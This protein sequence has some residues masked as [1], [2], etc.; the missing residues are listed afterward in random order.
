MKHNGKILVTSVID[1]QYYRN[2]FHKK[3]GSHYYKNKGKTN[4]MIMFT[5]TLDI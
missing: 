1:N 5:K 4:K 2:S 3:M